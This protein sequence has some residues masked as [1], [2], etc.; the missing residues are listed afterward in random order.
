MTT[1]AI[2]PARSGSRG[3]PHKNIRPLAGRELL[4]YS[5]AFAKALGLDGV[6]CSTD[7]S[8]YADLAEKC[9]AH[10]PFLRSPDAA[11]DT[12]MEHDVLND[13]F[14][15]LKCHG[16]KIPDLIVWLRPTFPFRDVDV[17][18]QCLKMVESQPQFS[19]GRVVVAAESRLYLDA[20]GVLKAAFEDKGKSMIRRQDVPEAYRVYSTDIIRSQLP[21]FTDEF[22]GQNVGYVKAPKLCGLDI[23]DLEDFELIE[24]LMI[25]KPELAKRF[26]FS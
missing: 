17:V 2:I 25:A 23:D 10:V 13:F 19:A 26:I 14:D 3:I 7:S 15:G 24:A 11:K 18:L 16:I 20:G 9:G 21:R 1:Y 6:F 12:S 22:L 8:N 4:S 5:I